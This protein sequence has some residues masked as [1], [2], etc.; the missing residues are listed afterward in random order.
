MPQLDATDPIADDEILYRRV[1]ESQMA[2]TE[3]DG[4]PNEPSAQGFS[5]GKN[6]TDGL[7]LCRGSYKTIEEAAVGRA[8]KTYYVAVLAAADLRRNGIEVVPTPRPDDPGHASIPALN[9]NDRKTNKVKV[10]E[11]YRLIATRLCKRI[12][13]PFHT[14]TD[15]E[16]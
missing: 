14:P 5:P 2:Q 11:M 9:P 13:G 10:K 15:T 7:S 16:A 8:G 3:E 1:P 12:E 6:D 4:L